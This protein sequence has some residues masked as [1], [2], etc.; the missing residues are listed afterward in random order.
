MKTVVIVGAGALGSHVAQFLRSEDVQLR[1]IDFDRTEPKNTLSQFHSKAG[2]S[3]LKVETLKQTMQFLWGVKIETISNKLVQNNAQ[4]LL[5]N[6]DL[7]I[8]CLDNGESRRVVQAYA[9]QDTL[10]R[11]KPCLHGALAADGAFG[12]VCWDQHFKIDDESTVGAPTCEDG[13]FLPFIA[14]VSSYIAYAAQT[15][16]RTSKQI[17]FQ[18]SPA[19]AIVV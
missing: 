2:V 16:L 5:S 3:K 8:D 7:I 14:I 4:A 19:G 18:V 1:V 10:G 11:S 12:R 15:F 9:R 13:Q 17:G 6:A